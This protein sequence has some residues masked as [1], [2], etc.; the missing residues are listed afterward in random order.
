MKARSFIYKRKFT[1]SPNSKDVAILLLCRDGGQ[2]FLSA[3]AYCLGEG[4]DPWELELRF[5]IFFYL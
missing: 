4:Y 3:G 1:V 2:L 5:F